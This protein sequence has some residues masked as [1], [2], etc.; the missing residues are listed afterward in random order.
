MED[1]ERTTEPTEQAEPETQ[2]K[3]GPL[4]EEKPEEGRRPGRRRRPRKPKERKMVGFGRLA[5]EAMP[6]IMSYMFRRR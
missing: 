3:E 4:K 5:F 1:I 6:E 2:P